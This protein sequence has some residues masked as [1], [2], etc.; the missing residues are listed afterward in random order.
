MKAEKFLLQMCRSHSRNKRQNSFCVN[1]LQCVLQVYPPFCRRLLIKQKT[2]LG[3]FPRSYSGFICPYR[4]TGQ[5]S[6]LVTLLVGIKSPKIIADPHPVFCLR[7]PKSITNNHTPILLLVSRPVMWRVE[8]NS[9]R[10]LCI[11]SVI[12]WQYSSGSFPLPLSKHLVGC[13]GRRVL[14]RQVYPA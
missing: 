2:R 12:S 1:Q 14:R 8:K 5:G 6:K 3:V 11:R 13:E 9:P 10:I 4:V 7:P